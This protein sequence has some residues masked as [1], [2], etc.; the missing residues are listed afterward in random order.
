MEK[1][2]TKDLTIKLPL[3][4]IS[5]TINQTKITNLIRSLIYGPCVLICKKIVL[6]NCKI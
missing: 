3:E 4:V 1:S 5:P 2:R 6:L